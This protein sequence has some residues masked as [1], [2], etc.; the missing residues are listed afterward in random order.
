[1]ISVTMVEANIY[2]V[3]LDGQEEARFRVT[4]SQ[5]YYREL[6]GLTVTHEWLIVQAFAFLMDQDHWRDQLPSEFDLGELAIRYP[7]FENALKEKL[8]V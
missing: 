6:C 5:E 1:M 7:L 3:V 2:E 4:M 8:L